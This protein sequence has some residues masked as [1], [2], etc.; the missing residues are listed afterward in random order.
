MNIKIKK[1][2]FNY[3]N[4]YLHIPELTLEKAQVTAIVGPNGAGKTTLLKCLSGILPLPPQTVLIN[5]LDLTS[6]KGANQARMISYVPQELSS[7]FNY[8]V[9]DFVLMG[10]AA[11]LNLFS[12]PS[13]TDKHLAQEALAYIGMA[14]YAQRPLFEL[15][16]GER[17][18]VL[19]ARALAQQ[20]QILYLDEPT[21]FLDPKHEIEVLDLIKKLSREKNKTIV[22]T[23]H[24]LEMAL[25]YSD[26]IVF[27]KQGRVVAAGQPN[28]IL[29]ESLLEKVYD[30]K[31]QIIDWNGKKFLVKKNKGP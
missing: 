30:L 9:Q 21:S 12:L 3:P 20:A 26:F 6:L 19:I 2:T 11:Y 15:S 22:L 4:F 8:T 31:F 25:E 24:N 1:L 23:L 18:L 17:R 27:I 16:S 10:R 28:Q 5:G 7:I 29:S 14:D 13:E